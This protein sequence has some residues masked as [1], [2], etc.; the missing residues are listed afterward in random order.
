MHNLT[1]H[2][3]LEELTYS[4]TAKQYNIDNRPNKFQISGIEITD[5]FNKKKLEQYNIKPGMRFE[6]QKFL[7]DKLNVNKMTVTKW[8]SKGWI[9]NL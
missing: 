1:E 3:T 6:S 4:Y 8:K 2:F 7:A 5:K 9:K